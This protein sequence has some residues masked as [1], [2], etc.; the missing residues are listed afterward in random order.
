LT[1]PATGWQPVVLKRK[2]DVVSW[3][4]DSYQTGLQQLRL[5]QRTLETGQAGKTGT[6]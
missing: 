2:V 6:V 4:A 3:K 5:M 1:E